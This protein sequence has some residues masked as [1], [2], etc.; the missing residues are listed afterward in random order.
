M[1][2][3]EA[4]QYHTGASQRARVLDNEF[5]VCFPGQDEASKKEAHL[6]RKNGIAQAAV[7]QELEDRRG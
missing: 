5:S 4:I 1:L 7:S 2:G 3:C 6:E